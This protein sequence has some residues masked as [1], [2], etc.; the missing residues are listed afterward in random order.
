MRIKS[1]K[2]VTILFLL[3]FLNGCAGGADRNTSETT[4]SVGISKDEYSHKSV[5]EGLPIS[6]SDS[7]YRLV[8]EEDSTGYMNENKSIIP[9]NWEYNEEQDKFSIRLGESDTVYTYFV[10]EKDGEIE[11]SSDDFPVSFVFL[12]DE[13]SEM[14]ILN[15]PSDQEE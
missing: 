7:Y 2:V 15:V 14:N 11:M 6:G 5:W 8:L 12:G 1:M 13:E 4:E 10:E 9:I 3:L